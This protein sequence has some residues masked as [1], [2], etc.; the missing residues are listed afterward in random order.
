M[1]IPSEFGGRRPSQM[2]H[3]PVSPRP[4]SVQ[5]DHAA[6]LGRPPAEAA[7]QVSIAIACVNGLPYI[8]EAIRSFEHQD[9]DITYEI[10]VADRCNRG[11]REVV[12][13]HPRTRLI[14]VD[15]AG[16]TI[17][18][19]RALAIRQARGELIGVTE[20]HCM[21]PPGWLGA[22]VRAHA[23]G[24]AIVG[25]PI[26]N[27]ATGR[28]I[29]WAVFFCE[30]SAFEPPLEAG[31]GAVPGNN[32]TYA[33]ALLPIIDDL[34]DL[35]V[36]EEE[37]NSRLAAHGYATYLDP[38]AAMM[39][40]KSFGAAEFVAQRYY[41]A[42]S[43]AGMRLRDGVLLQRLMYAGFAATLLAPL[44]IQRIVWNVWT[45]RRHRRELILSLPLLMTFVA[46]W[47][48]GEVVGYLTGPGDSLSRVE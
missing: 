18:Q 30:Y 25:G 42:R 20:D 6:D 11:C 27:A 38:S 29:D 24:H 15:R 3:G 2:P 23:A 35:G 22:M 8:E 36:W 1:E 37:F 4:K 12:R 33:R 9:G 48:L 17:P 28:L 21:A 44:L 7:T 13:R 43:Y 39:H 5:P 19:L 14:E 47:A 45:K 26:E 34:L 32:T 40:K 41:Y 31:P 10:L 46:A 16:V